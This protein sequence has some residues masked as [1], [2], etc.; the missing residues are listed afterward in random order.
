MYTYEQR[1][2]AVELYIKYGHRARAVSRELGYPP[3][4]F[5]LRWYK[6]YLESGDLKSGYHRGPKYSQEQ[7][8]YA[9][10]DYEKH[11]RCA[12]G[13]SSPFIFRKWL[14]EAYPNRNRGCAPGEQWYNTPKK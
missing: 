7:K 12:L 4:N 9:L 3:P 14:D 11:G 2:K 10:Q 8:Q 1:M 6:E 5:L 13:Y